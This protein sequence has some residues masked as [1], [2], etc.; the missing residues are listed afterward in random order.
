MTEFHAGDLIGDYRLE[1]RLGHGGFGTVWRARHANTGRLVAV[2]VLPDNENFQDSASLRA[3]VELLAASAA[4]ASPHIVRVLGGGIDPIPHIVM[5]FI[6]GTSLAEEL[7]TRGKLSQQEVIDAGL[8]IAEALEALRGVGIVHRDVKPSNV[9]LDRNGTIKLTDFGIAKIAGYDAVTATGQLPLSIAY[10]APEVW[11]GKAE[12]RSDLYAL[13][14][15]LYQCLTGTLPFRGAYAELFYQHRSKSPDLA[16]LPSGTAQSLIDLINVTL[17][18][19]PGERPESASTCI[20]LLERARE[21]LA[22]A[23]DEEVLVEP[24]RFGPWIKAA[25][26]LTQRW[27]WE[28]HN[29]ETGQDATVEVHFASD[30]A[31]GEGLRNAV[32][33]SPRL[34]PL[35]AERVLQT[36]RMILRPGEAWSNP[37]E[38][39]FQFWV[40][41]DEIALPEQPQQVAAPALLGYVTSLQELIVE[42][43]DAGTPLHLTSSTL[44]LLPDGSV[45]VRRP[46]L[47]VD[48]VGDAERDALDYLRSQPLTRDVRPLVSRAGS[49]EDLRISLERLQSLSVASA[50]AEVLPADRRRPSR[51][52][53]AAGLAAISMIAVAVV[54]IWQLAGNDG[55]GEEPIVAVATATVAPSTPVPTACEM[56]TFPLSLAQTVGSCAAQNPVYVFDASCPTGM[57]CR[58]TQSGSSTTIYVNDRTVVYVDADD[59]LVR[60]RES[61]LDSAPVLTRPTD[62][63]EAVD[64]SP[65]GR[66]LTYLTRVPTGQ[67]TALDSPAFSTQLW[68]VEVARGANYGLV[69]AS[70][71]ILGGVEALISSPQWSA[72]GRSIFF[73]W[74]TPGELGGDLFSIDVPFTATGDLDF[75][76]LRTGI[77]PTE[78]Y[79]ATSLVS[80][81]VAGSNFGLASNYFGAMGIAK[82]GQI[83]FQ[84]CQ[85]SGASRI[86]GVGLWDGAAASVLLAPAVGIVY[87]LPV[88][89][90]FDGALHVAKFAAGAWT[91][92]RIEAGVAIDVAGVRFLGNSGASPPDFSFKR[93]G[94][95][96]LFETQPG[97]LSL[98][99]YNGDLL[100]SWGT[101]SLPEWFVSLAPPT[102]PVPPPPPSPF[103]T[104]SPTPVASPTPTPIPVQPMDISIIVR[105]ANGLPVGGRVVTATINGVACGSVTT[106]SGLT[107]LR[108]PSTQAPASCRQSGSNVKFR[109]DGV[110]HTSEG[111]TFLPGTSVSTD[112]I[113]MTP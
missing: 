41:R 101:G 63:V 97:E 27:A 55:D 31:Y 59:Q 20:A 11:E 113:L 4:S 48:Y 10:A 61:S 89:S 99:G 85:G 100:G 104:P 35:G 3:D 108:I 33:A 98:V 80:H 109:I 73:L 83:H 40:A 5:E 50:G 87:G 54:A 69:V 19:D 65:D 91:L 23:E 88:A 70:N 47:E 24:V 9:L 13:G 46:G 93:T 103:A 42:A 96:L 14:V 22:N 57:A 67:E 95:A 62:G 75:T 84:L 72:D 110:D 90:P 25:P 32:A 51:M 56:L 44:W 60:A 94:D 105:N 112:L 12:H 45:H 78:T 28:C 38:G 68:V 71:D 37:P 17:R 86:C 66:Y 52:L 106:T 64:W 6:A 7:K 18:K 43:R 102:Q 58:S 79:I 74:R 111:V 49:L 77:Q 53:F 30:A 16:A 15:L 81:D 36:N 2:K 29:T 1:A 34:A 82:D 8:G 39:Q 26:H 76:Q 107:V 21:E 92:A